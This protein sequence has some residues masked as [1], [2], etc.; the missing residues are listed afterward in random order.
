MI[1][2][3]RCGD[4][5]SPVLQQ[6]LDAIQNAARC[7]VARMSSS[8]VATTPKAEGR[9]TRGGLSGLDRKRRTDM[10]TGPDDVRFQGRPEVGGQ[11]PK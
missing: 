10:A 9:S 6:R 4:H 1:G 2:S 8:F 11:R 3:R 7:G 5:R